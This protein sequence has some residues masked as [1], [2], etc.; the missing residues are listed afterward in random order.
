MIKSMGI[1]IGGIFIGAVGAEIIC[2]N[3]S[4]T[5]KSVYD[6]TCSITSGIT[7]AFNKG[8]ANAM[9]SQEAAEPSV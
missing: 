5:I 9:Q 1:L 8:Y 7:E 6:K 4:K 2:K 3:Y